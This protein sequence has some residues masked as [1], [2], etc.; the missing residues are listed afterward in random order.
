MQSLNYE[1]LQTKGN[2][3]LN[4]WDDFYE[5]KSNGSFKIA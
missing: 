3:P 1:I 4:E 2:F 5:H